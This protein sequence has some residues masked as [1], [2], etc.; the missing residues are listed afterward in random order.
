MPRTAKKAA[1]KPAKAASKKTKSAEAPAKKKAAAA[2]PVA[3]RTRLTK[4]TPARVMTRRSVE[5]SEIIGLIGSTVSIEEIA[6]KAYYIA[7][8]RRL[9]NMP[10]DS[11]S[12]WLQAERE[13][14]G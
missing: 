12:D 3:A 7:E 1:A 6:L 8:R 9:L 5:K 4:A 14:R 2:K 10:G 11:Q 13:L